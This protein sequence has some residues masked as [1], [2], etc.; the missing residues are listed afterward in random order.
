MLGGGLAYA[1][2]TAREAPGRMLLIVAVAA[3]LGIGIALLAWWRFRYTV[4]AGE[5]VIES[6]ILRRQRRVIPYDRV[7]DVS[8]ERR[9]LARLFG[10]AKV[11]IETG[12]SAADEGDLDMIALADAYALR[13]R[14]RQGA[15]ASATGAAE[16]AG[17]EP[18]LF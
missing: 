7:Q 3:L 17:Q 18:V 13:D 6:G 9:L 4:G 10:T 15:G 2:A 12:G 14:L 8:I 1:F 11:R 5:I 16:A